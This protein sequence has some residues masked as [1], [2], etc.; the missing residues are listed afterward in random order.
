V[1]K[2][3]GMAAGATKKHTPKLRPETGACNAIF[4][5]SLRRLGC[6][7]TT[8]LNLDAAIEPVLQRTL[9]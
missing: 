8:G 1:A 5:A 2:D 7:G 9:I 3:A 6:C 4:I